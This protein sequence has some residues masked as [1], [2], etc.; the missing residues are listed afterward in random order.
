VAT[1]RIYLCTF[2]LIDEDKLPVVLLS[3]YICS[4]DNIYVPF[5]KKVTFTELILTVLTQSR[6]ISQILTGYTS[7]RHSTTFQYF[8]FYFDRR[9][10]YEGKYGRVRGGDDL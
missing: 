4:I 7:F 1:I 3:G 6:N 5:R 10:A 2:C 9:Y 8:F